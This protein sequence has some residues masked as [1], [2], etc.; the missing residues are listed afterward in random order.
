MFGGKVQQQGCPHCRGEVAGGA[1]Q[2][3]CAS[4]PTCTAADSM[5][6]LGF[7]EVTCLP[8]ERRN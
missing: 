7:L 5:L 8:T 6:C 3:N 4:T 2:C 1:G